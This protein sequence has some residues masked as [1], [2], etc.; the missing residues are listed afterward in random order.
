MPTLA[1][2]FAHYQAEYLLDKAPN[3]QYQYRR[4]FAQVLRDV[5]PVPL[6]DLTPDC[7]RTWKMTLTQRHSRGTI[8]TYMQILSTVLRVAVEDYEWM[9]T[10]PCKR[11][12]KPAATPGR[13]R[14]LSAEERLALC[15]ACRQSAQPLLYPIVV[16][17]LST[18]GRKNEVVRLPWSEVDLERGL[19][20]FLHTKNRES[21][22]VAVVGEGLALLR[23]L[24][25]Q[26]SA[27]SPWVFPRA[28]GR[29][30]L[31]LTRV[32]MTARRRSGV[33]DFRFHDLRHTFASYMAMSGA[34]LRDI[35][36]ALGHKNIQQTMRYAHLL[37]SHTA[38]VVE[39]M[40]RQFLQG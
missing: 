40:A 17:A 12:R 34:T 16:V 38:G 21:R 24:A 35:A 18:G 8:R 30:P 14:F 2:L 36:E 13:V 29:K 3:T 39:R 19:V 4:F 33:Q 25:A 28:D 10:N 32:W 11:V 26:R 22:S 7:V 5:G 1:D 6:E 20:R 27:V 15:A 9:P 31:Y 37:P 23:A